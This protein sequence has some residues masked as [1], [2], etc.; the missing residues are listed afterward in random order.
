MMSTS[1]SRLLPSRQTGPAV[2]SRH[3][4]GVPR[5]YAIKFLARIL[6]K[7]TLVLLLIEAIFITEKLNDVLRSAI[8]QHA[9]LVAILAL[10]LLRTP[11][12]F[13]LALPLA[14]LIAIYQVFLRFREDR[15][16]L[17]LS[18]MGISAHHFLWLAI[19]VG[20]AAQI[21]SLIVSG[22]ISPAAVFAQRQLLFD[23]NYTA[24]RGGISAGQ[25]Y[26]FGSYTVFAGPR[27]KSEERHL[28]LHK[29]SDGEEQVIIANRALLEGPRDDGTM[30]LHLRDFRSTSFASFTRVGNAVA[31][32][33]AANRPPCDQCGYMMAIEPS[34]STQVGKLTREIEVSDLFRFDPRGTRSSERSLLDLMGMGSL[35]VSPTFDDTP[36]L[37]RRFGR[38]LLCM[39]APLIAGIAIIF[40]NRSSHVVALPL[41]CAILMSVDVSFGI[42]TEELS[43]FG[44][45]ASL[46]SIALLCIVLIASSLSYLSFRQNALVRPGLA[47]A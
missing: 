10:L 8:D 23:A 22:A 12:I 27:S 19:V 45:F 34:S 24:L 14:L 40:T 47:R 6:V 9:S 38:G 26:R 28:F 2:S 39:I 13:A 7:M 32:S 42:L 30:T 33:S 4:A 46:G 29:A 3:R 11:E 16:L 25:F 17:I 15:E 37:G 1:N 21:V 43:R 20:F 31:A 5:L 36:E 18:G 41:A 35:N 44:V